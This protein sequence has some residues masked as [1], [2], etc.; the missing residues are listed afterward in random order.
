MITGMPSDPA[1]RAASVVDSVLWH[2]PHDRS[3]ELCRLLATA[4]GFALEGLVLTPVQGAPARVEYRVDADPGWVA[5][6]ARIRIETPASN[7]ELELVRDGDGWRAEGRRLDA[8]D[9][10]I[11]I[12]LRV[13]PATNTL[14]IRRLA[15]DVGG[16]ADVRAA[17][18]GFPGL[19]VEPLDQRYERR[20][21]DSYRYRAGAFE[22]DLLV[23]DSGLVL[24]YGSEYWSALARQPG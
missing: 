15:L 13:T 20:S 1:N 22:A 9:G 2:N 19:E 3:T 23:A 6:R 11:D 24:R 10:C 5:H 17:W 18:V 16:S 8:M 7:N 21:E 4:S 12:D 14:P